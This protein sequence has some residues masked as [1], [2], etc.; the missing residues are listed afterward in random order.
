[1]V[2]R[3]VRRNTLTVWALVGALAL[4]L[5]GPAQ[6]RPSSKLLPA[7]GALFGAYVNPNDG[8]SGDRTGRGEV[9]ELESALDR[10]LDIVHSYYDWEDRFPTLLERWTVAG[11]R[12]PLASWS[13]IKLERI[14][15][16][17]Q[18][19]VIRARARA[20]RQLGRT[21]FI[22]WGWEMNGSWFP[23]SGTAN[24]K[25]PSAYVGAWRRIYRIFREERAT[26]A[27][28][29]WCPNAADNPQESWNHWRNYYPGDRYVD[30]VG[31]DVYNWGS[32]RSWSSWQ[33]FASLVEP[34]YADY[35]R[36]KPIMIAETGSVEA[37]G[38]KA[39]WISEARASIKRVFPSIG[40][41]VWFHTD[42]EEDWRANSSAVSFSAFERMAKDP[43]F[44]LLLRR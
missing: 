32:R 25:D 42:H 24:G 5:P 34:V 26:N 19:A 44:N 1:M 2:N 29:V 36:R 17:S 43:Y 37:G 3:F 40:A 22:R 20:V 18:D 7:R 16:G 28:W 33:S 6:A 4:L 10:K 35:A 41:F 11:D 31:I 39:R 15:N 21:T 30:W 38:S 27:V 13:G 8:W 14:V 9:K 12:I 23:W